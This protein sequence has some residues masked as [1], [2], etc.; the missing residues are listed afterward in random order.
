MAVTQLAAFFPPTS[1][2]YQ[3]LAIRESFSSPSWESILGAAP[4]S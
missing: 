2:K 4:R 1:A 3:L